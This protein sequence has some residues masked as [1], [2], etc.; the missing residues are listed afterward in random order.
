MIRYHSQLAKIGKRLLSVLGLTFL[1]AVNS[2]A[3]TS[4]SYTVED[5]L[6]NSRV[7]S[8]FQ[9]SR[10]NVWVS[11]N[12]GLN[13]FDGLDFHVYRHDFA[14]DKSLSNN[15]C[16]FVFE[17]SSDCIFVATEVGIQIFDYDRDCFETVPMIRLGGDT[18]STQPVC[19]MEMPDGTVVASTSGYGVFHYEN[20]CFMESARYQMPG[21]TDQ[22][23]ADSRGRVWLSDRTGNIYLRNVPV[24][25]VKSVI[26]IVESSL[27]FIY[28]ASAGDGLFRYDESAGSLVRVLDDG[29]IL[30]RIRPCDDGRLFLCTDGDGLMYFDERSRTVDKSLIH[31][32][33]YKFSESNVTDAFY[34]CFGNMWVGVYWK[35]VEVRPPKEYVF[36]ESES[37]WSF[38]SN[39][40][41]NCVTAI[42]PVCESDNNGDLW[43]ATVQSGL[44]RLGRNGTKKAHYENT[45]ISGMP[46]TIQAIHTDG[47]GRIW[48]GA[49]AGGACYL[50]NSFSRVVKLSQLVGKEADIMPAVNDIV[51]DSYSRI[52]FA[53]DGGGL[54]CLDRRNGLPVLDHY[55]G[56]VGNESLYPYCILGNLNVNCLEIS[57]NLL[58][59]GT[60]DGLELFSLEPEGLSK[61]ARILEMTDVYDII[62]YES[63]TYLVATNSGLYQIGQSGGKPSVLA[64]YTTGNGLGDNG[65]NSIGVD[66]GGIVWLGTDNG[67]SRLETSTSMI[68][69]FTTADGLAENEYSAQSGIFHQG[70]MY[71]GN[72]GGIVFFDSDDISTEVGETSLPGKVRIAGILLNGV[73]VKAGDMSGSRVITEKWIPETDCIRLSHTDRSFCLELTVMNACINHLHYM[74]RIDSG[75]WNSL[76]KSQKSINI[77]N[78]RA[79]KHVV[80]IRSEECDESCSLTIMAYRPWYVSIAALSFYIAAIIVVFVTI[81]RARRQT[82]SAVREKEHLKHEVERVRNLKRVDELNVDSPDDLFMQRVMKIINRNLS[83]PD[84]NVEFLADKIGISRAHFYRRLKSITDFSPVEFLK[85]ARLQEAARLLT[86]RNCD[87]S[88]AC[89]ATGFKSVSAFSTAF[90][91]FYGMTPTQYIKDNVK[92]K[93]NS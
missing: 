22:I 33:K 58:L 66:A 90:K 46:V 72:T 10:M 7:W 71:F 30:N 86:E 69:T 37:R 14:N 8:L 17:N 75:T 80:E 23:L 35:G 52:W 55:T 91:N 63:G 83:N 76:P 2:W 43:V 26:G 68:S 64:H 54:Y 28:V 61:R 32:F 59:A 87:V 67:L 51:H 81:V 34:D 31:S 16:K 48:L 19:M 73:S 1:F 21:V 50:D 53:T 47:E 11:T 49:S 38:V 41:T 15:R 5:G 6:S 24:G 60:S 78:L 44:Y 65:V 70:K 29:I 20:G 36:S 25:H 13:R 79:G 88:D 62:K 89:Q 9:D 74:Y 93:G 42:E 57:G 56:T 3:W 85:N 12:N 4:R 18:I 92:S 39:I 82:N 27:G 84:M 40:G 77:N 45:D